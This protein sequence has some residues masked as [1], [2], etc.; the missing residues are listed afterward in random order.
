MK[1]KSPSK[2]QT[3]KLFKKTSPIDWLAIPFL[4]IGFVLIKI[5]DG[6]KWLASVILNSVQNLFA[7]IR[8]SKF[9]Y[10][11]KFKKS[12]YKIQ[13][14]FG[15]LKIQIFRFVPPQRDPAL[16]VISDF[17][18][19]I[20]NLWKRMLKLIQHDVKKIKITL[21][22]LPRFNLPKISFPKIRSFRFH[23]LSRSQTIILRPTNTKHQ[24]LNTKLKWFLLGVSFTLLF[25]FLPFQVWSWLEDLPKPQLLTQR[26]IPVTTK[27]FDRQGYLLYE[28][29]A[30]QNRTPVVLS[31]LPKTLIDATIAIEDRQFYSH[32]GFS[33]RGILRSVRETLF[34]HRLQGGS[35]ITQQLIRSAFLTPEPT[36]TRKLKELLLSFWAEKLYTKN[37][38]LEMYFNQ[39]PY[40][41]TAWGAEAASQTY[42]G[43]PVKSLSLAESAFLAGLPSAPSIFSPFGAN[44]EKGLVRQ[45]EVLQRMLDDQ[46]ITRDEA[47]KARNQKL[48]FA[49]PKTDIKAPHFVM[50]VKD[51]LEKKYGAGLVKMGGLRVTTSLDLSVQEIA[52]DIV[53]NQVES[54]K[55]FRVG[56]G[57]A[58]II[59]PAT[60]EILAM[61]GSK[62]YWDQ[63]QD[64]NV[65]VT[66][67][68]RQPGSAIKVVN[69]ALAL[70]KGFT[71]ATIIDDSP[72]SFQSPGQPTYT[73]VNYDN[74]FHGQ[75]TLRQALANSYNIPAVK[76]LSKF[77]VLA[78]VEKGRQMGITSWIDPSRYGLSL[79][80]G[81]GEV[82]MLDLARAYG[83]IANSGN[84]KELMP[85]LKI[86]DYK[87]DLLEEA[88]PKETEKVISK[89]VA[90]LLANILA[91][92][93]ARSAAFGINSLLKITGKT[94]SV[95]TGTTNNLRDN[96]AIGFT[97]SY[98]VVSWVGNNDNTPMS[99]IASGITGATPIWN[100]IMSNLLKDKTDEP[101]S[102]PAEVIR[103]QA[104]GRADFFIAGTEKT[105]ACPPPPTPS[106]SPTPNP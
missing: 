98:V 19:R 67:S 86:T 17:V 7:K 106:P 82:T 93:Q 25:L 96:W 46:K 12:K 69:Y 15:N 60:G 56:N 43:K 59:R 66:L 37:Q 54:L 103:S 14:L 92:D 77:G 48:I 65:N 74:K 80:L 5:G 24:I 75:V 71:P 45:K 29:Y 83:T 90:F 97:P 20:S 100:Q 1:R 42:F 3:K 30:D 57:A 49:P 18:L 73:P 84:L 50:Y 36:L 95:K 4:A 53:K 44:P 88:K 72:I 55:N 104:C 64:G 61:V 11:N 99:G 9:E 28:I 8:I 52:E 101:F 40:G 33:V 102:Q 70:E 32:Q 16:A 85:I 62:D 35:T 6:V 10:R 27:I 58:L 94:V 39:V 38:I 21:S 76:T 26:E 22:S 2:P 63:G 89:G 79:T 81:G 23:K 13:K 91:D 51:L 34:N 41:G 47:Q 31:R 78:M 105:V 87:G 68:L